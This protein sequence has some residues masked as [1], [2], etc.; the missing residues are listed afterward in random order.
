MMHEVEHEVIFDLIYWIQRDP[1]RR[2]V[3]EQ[4]TEAAGYRL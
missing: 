4:K 1:V 2:S 3:K